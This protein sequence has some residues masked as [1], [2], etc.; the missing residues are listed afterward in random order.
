[1]KKYF[2]VLTNCA[3]FNDT[4]SEDLVNMLRCLSAKDKFYKKNDFIFLEEDKAEYVGI[5]ITGSVCVI[6]EDYWGNRAILEKLEPGELFGETYAL[7]DIDSLPIS[8]IATQDCEVILIDCKKIIRTCS[9]CCS[10]HSKL[11]DNLLKIVAYKNLALNQKIHHLV[12]R[13]TREKLISYLSEQATKYK[14]NTFKI[15]FNR[16]ELADYLSVE[17]SA[18]SNELSK[19]RDEGIIEFNKNEFILK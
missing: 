3:L 5:V 14:S 17:R 19:L 6:K 13:T 18:M 2:E 1:M 4:T 10:F 15:P 7:A 11:I 8:V 9:N 12:Q 16:Q